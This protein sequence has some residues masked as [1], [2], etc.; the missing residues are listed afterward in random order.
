LPALTADKVAVLL[1]VVIIVIVTSA[2]ASDLL[3]VP[4]RKRTG[5]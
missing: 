1:I 2:L 5:S 3:G 4:A